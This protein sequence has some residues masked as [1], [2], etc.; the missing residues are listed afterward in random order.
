MVGLSGR[1]GKRG[2]GRSERLFQQMEGSE[3][4]LHAAAREG[5]LAACVSLLVEGADID[6]MDE[7][8]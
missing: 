6:A 4:S 1:A 8:A 5:D 7:V 2:E 3:T